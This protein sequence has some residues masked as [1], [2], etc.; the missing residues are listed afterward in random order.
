VEGFDATVPNIARVWDYWLGGKDNFAADREL[1]EKMLD[2]YPLSAEMAKEN[3][4]FLGKAVSYV[5]G[6]G[7]EQFI[8]VGAGLPT[9]VNTHDAACQAAPDA[10]VAYIDNDPVVL[11]HAKALLAQDPNV[12]AL[13]G[14]VRDPQAILADPDL[15]RLISWTQPV[16]VLLCGVLH[17]LDASQARRVAAAFTLA[18]PPG[19]YLIISV[20]TGEDDQL[21]TDF[22]AAYTAA[23]L[24]FHSPGQIIAFFSGLELVSP[25]L[26]PA[27]AWTANAPLPHLEPRHGTFYAGVGRK[28]P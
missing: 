3:R 18:M 13:P 14:D 25:G 22:K 8:D 11:A 1:A 2:L 26:V 19:S 5:A 17:F 20:G 10:K 28:T 9:A 16:C 15:N 7:I 6:Q 12:V 24:Y 4:Q 21:S 27:R 23:P